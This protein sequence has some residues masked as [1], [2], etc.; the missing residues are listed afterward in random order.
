MNATLANRIVEYESGEMCLKEQ[1]K[2]FSDLVKS[3]VA[4]T[5]QGI[6]GRT[7]K[8]MIAHGLFDE[9]GVINQEKLDEFTHRSG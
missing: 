5:L 2:L 3:G 6:Y 7:A 9:K 1:V 4:Y 8:R